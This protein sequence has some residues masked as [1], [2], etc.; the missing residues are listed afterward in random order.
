MI[1]QDYISIL[2]RRKFIIL[3][4]LIATLGTVLIAT[5]RIAP[6]YEAS[7][8]LRIAVS[9]GGS[10]SYSDYM[11]AD[12]LMNTYIQ[13]AT[14][15]PVMEELQKHINL[16]SSTQINAAIIPNTELIRI[17]VADTDP[18]LSAKVANA[19]ADILVAQKAPQY[20][21]GKLSSQELLRDQIAQAK[22][23][24]DQAQQAYDTLQAQ[25][26]LDIQQLDAAK[27]SVEM[28]QNN[29][30]RLNTQYDEVTLQADSQAN[31]APPAQ[32]E[33]LAKQKE[34]LAQQLDQAKRDL[35][36]VQDA[37]NMLLKQSLPNSARLDAAD[38][39]L[40]LKRD[41]YTTLST[42]YIQMNLQGEIRENMISMVNP[43][44]VPQSSSR[45]N[46]TLNY[47]LGL[48]VGLIGGIGLALL[49]E[50]LDTTLYEIRDIETTS[51]LPAFAKIPDVSRKEMCTFQDNFSPAAEAFRNVATN[52]QIGDHRQQK[53]VLLLVSAEPN[54]GKSMITFHLACSL[55]ELGNHIVAVDC[56]SRVPSLHKFFHLPNQ[57]GLKDV[58][59][60]QVCLENA[61]QKS[62]FEGVEVLTSGSEMAHPTQMLSSPQMA[63][64]IKLLK[65]KYDYV[66]LDS[67]A[68]LA[69]AD[70]SALTPVADGF[71]LVVRQAHAQKAAVQEAG[72]FLAGQNG[73]STFLIIN[74][75]GSGN[76]Y[77]NNIKKTATLSDVRKRFSLRKWRLPG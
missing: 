38:Q 58:L 70:V 64:L 13:I 49:F 47:A 53:R 6:V 68:M 65:Q 17:T 18:V 52:L 66:L 14:S 5:K 29:Y 15:T 26:L 24:F 63:K 28:K 74:Q 3:L 57:T 46:T 51:K 33:T 12:R 23:D 40:R 60:N 7:A 71:V 54:Q 41:I 55:A 36:Q 50:N 45:P 1:I 56:D 62:E 72:Y 20:T 73:K 43:A 77:Y 35:A 44:T 9:S 2:W 16:G 76:H 59:E 39:L 31:N 32:K 10:L 11:Y 75:V 21:G 42:Q 30:E 67:P 27:Q 4:A 34:I 37:Y 69:V 19:L 25:S 22:A 8:V 48:I 61:L